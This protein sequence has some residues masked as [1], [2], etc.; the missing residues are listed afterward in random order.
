MQH[1]ENSIFIISNVYLDRRRYVVF[2]ASTIVCKGATVTD[3]L[4]L[5]KDHPAVLDS[6]NRGANSLCTYRLPMVIIAKQQW[7]FLSV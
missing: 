6:R 3:S 4:S 1:S 7:L 2:R 5:A